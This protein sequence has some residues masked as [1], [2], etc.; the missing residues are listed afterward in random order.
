MFR[1]SRTIPHKDF[2]KSAALKKKGKGL[3]N[4]FCKIINC[5][6]MTSTIK[7]KVIDVVFSVCTASC[8]DVVGLLELG[9]A[10]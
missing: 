7:I 2:R 4:H 3:V 6:Y 8:E 10:P 1:I 9:N 5:I